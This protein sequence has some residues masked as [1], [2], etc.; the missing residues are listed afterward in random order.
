MVRIQFDRS[1]ST[2]KEEPVGVEHMVV[3][4]SNVDLN[5]M[6][7]YSAYYV[8][9]CSTFGRLFAVS[10]L[11]PREFYVLNNSTK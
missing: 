3:I 9:F 4:H 7:I 11:L 6:A 2:K 10:T 1:K 8:T 5:S